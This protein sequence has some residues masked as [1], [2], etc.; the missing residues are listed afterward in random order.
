MAPERLRSG[1]ASV[2]DDLYALALTLWEM[3]TCRVP[4]PGYKPRA[5]PMRQQIMF[6]VPAS[7]SIDE[8][9]QIFNGLSP[10]AEMRPPARYMRFFN[11]AQLTT[12]P[13]QTPRAR[14]NA[15]PPLGRGQTVSFQPDVQAL[16]V[17][18]ATNTP[19]IVGELFPL[20]KPELTLGRQ[21]S[22]DIALPEAT[23]SGHHAILRWQ[24]GSW[25][26]EDTGSTNGTYADHDYERK[27]RLTMIHGG[28]GQVGE[29]RFK[30][31]NFRPHSKHHKRAQE[32]LAKRDG[33]TGLLVKEHLVAAITN[34]CAFAEWYE[35]PMQVARYELRGPNRQV[36]DRPTILEMLALRRAAAR[37]IELTEMLLTSLLPVEAGRTGPLKFV[38]S[39]VGPSLDES[40]HVVEQVVSQVRGL[41]P[42]TIEL[43]ATLVKWEPGKSAKSL[44]E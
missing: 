28:E 2:E 42:D 1:G 5:K 44:L 23:V 43:V 38:V 21:S 8:V 15:G 10:E 14:L 3:W 13:V 4:E 26:L 39:M 29:C 27:K 35:A 17:T 41:L 20:E 33:L 34:E 6:D 12:S 16:L 30:L 25:E 31:V 22:Q 19:E 40:R 37:V 7:L 11:P 18:Y 24:S 32:F 36:S 9:K